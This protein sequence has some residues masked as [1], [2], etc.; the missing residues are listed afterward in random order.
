MGVAEEL[1]TSS[2][3]RESFTT[4]L[5]TNAADVNSDNFDPV[6]L[7]AAEVSAAQAYGGDRRYGD[8]DGLSGGAI[9]GIVIVLLCGVALLV[10]AVV[11]SMKKGDTT[12]KK[13]KDID[14]AS[15]ENRGLGTSYAA[16][17]DP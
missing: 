4:T 10:G 6:A 1:T 13:H 16:H 3:A 8:D 5:V 17:G 2:T 9:A 11:F 12:P 14:T 15:P 7:T